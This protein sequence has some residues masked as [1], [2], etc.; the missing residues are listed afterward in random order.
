M[1]M[2]LISNGEVIAKEKTDWNLF[3]LGF[4]QSRKA[5]TVFNKRLKAMEIMGQSR[6]AHP[7][8]QNKYICL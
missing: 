8:S 5:I 4:A 6:L 7:I 2:V 1:A 3:T